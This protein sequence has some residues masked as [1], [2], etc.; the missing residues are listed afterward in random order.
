M[1]ACTGGTGE[2][3]WPIR[4]PPLPAPLYFIC[5]AAPPNAPAFLPAPLLSLLLV[6][7]SPTRSV[8]DTSCRS[9]PA[10]QPPLRSARACILSF[11]PCNASF[12]SQAAQNVTGLGV[13]GLCGRSRGW[14]EEGA[15]HTAGANC[16]ACRMG[17]LSKRKEAH[18]APGR[19]AAS[20][21]AAL[22]PFPAN[23]PEPPAGAL[24][25]ASTAAAVS[26]A[27]DAARC[28][29]DAACGA[30]G[31]AAAAPGCAAG[32]AAAAA[33]A[34]RCTLTT[35][36]AAPLPPCPPLP[37]CRRFLQQRV[38]STCLPGIR[39]SET[40]GRKPCTQPGLTGPPPPT[41]PQPQPP[42][43]TNATRHLAHTHAYTAQPG[44]SLHGPLAHLIQA[45]SGL[46]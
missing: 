36:V 34:G 10:R 5:L 33:A 17:P 45:R 9:P 32:A 25:A 28:G 23:S 43:H 2:Q 15:G 38:G 42:P 20:A 39:G 6:S 7:V 29:V 1:A 30:A 40:P 46:T 26:G 14:Q 3:A 13:H 44:G 27:A 35:A 22:P 11:Q 41:P 12:Y 4:P 24:S 19:P 37:R 18:A 31:G 21:A 16:K 8:I